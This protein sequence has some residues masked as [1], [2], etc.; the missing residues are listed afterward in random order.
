L[1]VG[2]GL[3]LWFAKELVADAQEQ[4]TARRGPN[5]R[6]VMGTIGTGTNRLRSP[7]GQPTGRGERGIDDMRAAISQPDVQMIAVADVDAV[8]KDFAANIV[9]RDCRKFED[10]RE[11]LAVRDIDAVIIGTPDHWHAL[12]A[13]AAMKAGKHV[14]CEKPLTLTLEEGRALVRVQRETGKVFQTGSQQRT[15][16]GGR[17]RLACEMVRNGRIGTIRQVTSIVATN[18]NP[19]SPQLQPEPVPQ[20]LNWDFWL[21]PTAETPF[22]RRRCHYEF[23]WWYDYSGGKMTDWGAHMNDTVQCALGTDGT[24]PISVTGAGITPPGTNNQYNVHP[25]FIVNYVYGNGPN[26]G[27]GTRLTCRSSFPQGWNHPRN[28]GVLFEGDPGKWIWVSRQTI[29][30]ND[31]NAQ[32]SRILNDPLGDNAIRLE[33]AASHMG[34]FIDCCRSG[35]LPICNVGVGHRSAS[36]CHL[37]NI[38]TRFFPGL[39]LGWNPQDERFT[40]EYAAAANTHLGRPYR[41]P[42]R[43]DA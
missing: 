18:G 6:I 19:Q 17:F 28:E 12:I 36:V 5:D 35:R 7:T 32:T 39:T 34:N 10:F 15:E 20:G 40:G 25:Q 43:L 2:A 1:A 41:A 22:L 4:K 8:N 38:A 42:W 26:G 33:R 37:G 24:G 30:A 21:G 27:E 16:F 9:G 29:V 14:Y 23:R 13:I 3:P 31:G 11:L